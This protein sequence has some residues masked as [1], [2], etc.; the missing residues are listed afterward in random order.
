MI[1]QWGWIGAAKEKRRRYVRQIHLAGPG[2]EDVYLVTDL[3]DERAYPAEDLLAVY[4]KR[5]EIDSVFQKIS[6]VFELLGLL[7]GSTPEANALP[8]GVLPG[9]V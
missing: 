4:L 6:E 3:V 9:A 1:D 7:I 5:W 8:G 2:A